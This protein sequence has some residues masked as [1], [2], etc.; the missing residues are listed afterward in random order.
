MMKK[1]EEETN[2]NITL[3]KQKEEEGYKGCGC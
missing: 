2:E 3:E 1:K